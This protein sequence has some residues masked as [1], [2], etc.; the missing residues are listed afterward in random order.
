MIDVADGKQ[1]IDLFQSRPQDKRPAGK[2]DQAVTGN[3]PRDEA[4]MEFDERITKPLNQIHNDK[5]QRDPK[6]DGHPDSQL[7]DVRL[8]V[9]R[10]AFAFDR[11][12]QQIVES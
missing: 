9:L 1:V 2:Y 6:H 5:Q 3:R 12:V 8:A 10:D 4:R 11:D 7:A